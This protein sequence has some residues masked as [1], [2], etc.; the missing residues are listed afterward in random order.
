M[1]SILSS[2]KKMLGIDEAYTHFDL[3]IIV[4][5]NATLAQLTQF[6]IGPDAGFAISGID[7][8]WEMFMGTNPRLNMVK[9]YVY[10]RVRYLFDPPLSSAA[11]EAI[12]Q[13]LDE[14]GWRLNIAAEDSR[15][16][17]KEVTG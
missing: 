4:H 15:V 13:Q 3:D 11:A 16:P 6:G 12:K 14:F 17:E 9:S 2:V 1:D 7:E 10:M 5:I 8:T